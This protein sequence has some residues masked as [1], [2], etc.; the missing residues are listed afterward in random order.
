MRRSYP[1]PIATSSDS[2]EYLLGESGGALMQFGS[3]DVANL[4]SADVF[5]EISADVVS[6]VAA[7]SRRVATGTFSAQTAVSFP[8]TSYTGYRGFQF[9]FTRVKLASGTGDLI[10]R[11]STDGGDNYDSG[12]S[13]YFYSAPYFHTAA[14]FSHS[15]AATGIVLD[16]WLSAASYFDVDVTLWN[17][18]AADAEGTLLRGGF[19]SADAGAASQYVGLFSGLR[20]A[21]ADVDAV[22]ISCDASTMSGNYVIYG[23]Y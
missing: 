4:I 15:V 3:A 14:G 20:V 16:N 18:S 6:T 1:Y 12:A 9:V 2:L 10:I 23:L 19:A 17:P 22:Q 13:E 8:L 11:T 7:G 5:T 21:N